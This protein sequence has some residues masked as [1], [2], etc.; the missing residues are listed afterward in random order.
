MDCV[1]LRR[2]VRFR[3]VGVPEVGSS[4]RV[5]DGLSM[6]CLRYDLNTPRVP[7]RLGRY[8]SAGSR[9][10]LPTAPHF[11]F[12]QIPA[13]LSDP[14]PVLRTPL[15]HSRSLSFFESPDFCS[16]LSGRPESRVL[17]NHRGSSPN[18]NVTPFP[19]TLGTL[20]KVVPHL[21]RLSVLRSDDHS[22]R[23]RWG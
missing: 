10:I 15:N 1:H 8:F 6:L 17:R 14:F 13:P 3:G 2:S 12:P 7:L 9:L 5:D 4:L 19:L 11:P 16:S 18:R 22:S 23:R 20:P 21:F